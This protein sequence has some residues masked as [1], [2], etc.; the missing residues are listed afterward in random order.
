MELRPSSVTGN[1]PGLVI[2]CPRLPIT[3]RDEGNLPVKTVRKVVEK[4]S[5]VSTAWVNVHH[6]RLIYKVR[7]Q[8]KREKGEVR[9]QGRG[10]LVQ[11][12]SYWVSFL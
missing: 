4:L 3:Q 5:R 6:H 1:P 11:G 10:T 9:E 12:F 7:T 2:L 8:P